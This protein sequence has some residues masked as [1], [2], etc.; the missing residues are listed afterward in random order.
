VIGMK[1]AFRGGDGS[2]TIPNTCIVYA[3]SAPHAGRVPPLL[4]SISTIGSVVGSST[5][6]SF[7][8]GLAMGNEAASNPPTRGGR[9][10]SFAAPHPPPPASPKEDDPHP[11]RSPQ[12]EPGI[13]VAGPTPTNSERRAQEDGE[14]PEGLHA[15]SGRQVSRVS[16]APG[17]AAP[18]SPSP[19]H[20][21]LKPSAAGGAALYH[22][23][24]LSPDTDPLSS[25]GGGSGLSSNLRAPRSPQL[26]VG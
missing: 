2:E 20:A 3:C 11:L 16:F 19:G 5:R 21:G 10:V 1:N 12:D 7:K 6:P 18:A 15:V 17:V 26:T 13:E 23:A 22:A 24:L 9:R 25:A 14:D 4:R 8:S